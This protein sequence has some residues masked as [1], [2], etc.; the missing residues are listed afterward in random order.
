MA[1]ENQVTY[2]SL[3]S[4]VLALYTRDTNSQLSTVKGKHA[5]FVENEWSS[6]TS[7]N[8]EASTQVNEFGVNE[9]SLKLN[10]KQQS[11][12]KKL[13]Q[14]NDLEFTVIKQCEVQ[15]SGENQIRGLL[16]IEGDQS[17][18]NRWFLSHVLHNSRIGYEQSVDGTEINDYTRLVADIFDKE[19]RNISKDDAWESTG[20][21]YFEKVVNFYTS[22]YVKI[23][24]CLPAFPAKSCNSDKVSGKL[25]DKGEELALKRLVDIIGLVQEVYPPGIKVW[26][27]S[28][29]HVFSDCGK[30]FFI[31]F[32]SIILFLKLKLIY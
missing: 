13:F 25:P 24:A 7:S 5:Q 32:L 26:V 16:M 18:F 11:E 27:V 6:L 8:S 9:K 23:E 2:I 30:F 1:S 10:D 20:R 3:F 31:P 17:E 15:V 22:R 21:S 14:G 19:L 28:D 29:G 4:R 12:L